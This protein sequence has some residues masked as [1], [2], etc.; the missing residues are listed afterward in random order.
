MKNTLISLSKQIVLAIIISVGLVLP[1]VARAEAFNYNFYYDSTKDW[2]TTNGMEKFPVSPQTVGYL[3][4]NSSTNVLTVKNTRTTTGVVAKGT[5]SGGRWYAPPGQRISQMSFDF[6][7]VYKS[8]LRFAV[9]G[10]NGSF[11]QSL[12]TYEPTTQTDNRST[13][14]RVN[15][16]LPDG[17]TQL[18][19]RGWE[20]TKT[21]VSVDIA[22]TSSVQNLS[23]NTVQG[24]QY[25]F[26]I[27]DWVG[28]GSDLTLFSQW[29]SYMKSIGATTIDVSSSWKWVE[30]TSGTVTTDFIRDRLAIC[31]TY[32]V[33]MRL[34]I[35]THFA[36]AIPSWYAG[37]VWRAPDGSLPIDPQT[38]TAVRI[39]SLRD[40]TFQSHIGTVYKTIASTFAGRN[41]SYMPLF[42]YDGEIKYRHWWC[43]DASTLTDWR[44]AINAT[45]RPT[46]LSRVAGT[47]AL[48]STP[49]APDTVGNGLPDTSVPNRAFIAYRE[50]CLQEALS[51]FVTQ[52]RAGDPNAKIAVPLGESYRKDSALFSN[53]DYYGMSKGANYIVHSYDFGGLHNY[54]VS[55]PSNWRLKSTLASL[56]GITRKPVELEFDSPTVAASLGYTSTILT[57]Y[58]KNCLQ[59]GVS[60][61]FTNFC[62][63]TLAELANYP[64][65]ANSGNLIQ[66]SNNNLSPKPTAPPNQTVL[67]FFSKWAN[68]SY[69]VQT[70]W[71]HDAQFGYWLMLTEMGVPIR[72]ICEDNLEEDLS[73]YRGIITAF[74]PPETMPQYYQDKLN[75]LSL[76]KIIEMPK[77]P[78][79]WPGAA[80]TISG[81][82][83]SVTSLAPLQF[84]SLAALNGSTSGYSV[85][86]YYNNDATLPLLL[87]KTNEVKMGF[88][89]G[90]YY[91]NGANSANCRAIMLYAF[92]K[93]GMY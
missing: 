28:P 88:P 26:V 74:S 50:W 56:Q 2:F 42:G 17:I 83:G 37:D 80:S 6:Y 23:L 21:N 69:R 16:T 86:L 54:E 13:P 34:R 41:I 71:L 57:E 70:E 87:Y 72:I 10:G 61:N 4:A 49:P 19:I 60:F 33:Q 85:G 7:G 64:L 22:W 66:A 53:L 84:P 62:Y 77:I 27:W 14:T 25:A 43:Y 47:T 81:T 44:T 65:L 51:L 55:T 1:S 63:G 15:V 31:D 90:Y 9:Y 89:L 24:N 79:L 30:P 12:Y 38:S 73:S 67:L 45:T 58:A 59:M 5:A 93:S 68:Y 11:T 48:A 40:G 76:K 46:W 3:V 92:Q 18:E 78:T 20:V 36:D 8:G 35:N 52:I 91:V 32:G 39:P 82:A 75:T 29:V